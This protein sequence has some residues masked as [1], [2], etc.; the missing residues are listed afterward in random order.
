MSLRNRL[1]NNKTL[2]EGKEIISSREKELGV[3]LPRRTCPLKNGIG[4]LDDGENLCH[5]GCAW[6]MVSADGTRACAGAGRQSFKE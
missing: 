5:A 1:L 6:L 4:V 3:F 2:E